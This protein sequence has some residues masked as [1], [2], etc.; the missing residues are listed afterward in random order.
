MT[1]VAVKPL[2]N[3]TPAA[4]PQP[5]VIRVVD[6]PVGSISP[7]TYDSHLDV[8]LRLGQINN[9]AGHLLGRALKMMVRHPAKTALSFL[10]MTFE[11]FTHPMRGILRCV[12]SFTHDGFLD[13]IMT[14]ALYASSAITTASFLA[15]A[16]ALLA[17]PFTGGASLAIIPIASSIMFYTGLSDAAMTAGMLAKDEYDGAHA[18]SEEKVQS[19]EQRLADDY[20]NAF[21][22][23]VTLPLSDAS[24]ALTVAPQGML[25]AA[26]GAV[27]PG[28]RNAGAAGVR[29][30][31]RGVATRA[32]ARAVDVSTRTDSHDTSR[33][34]AVTA[35][36]P[37]S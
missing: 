7:D 35:T 30:V 5:P 9:E 22:A 16:V 11:P 17:A 10:L 19:V 37:R 29:N 3:Q 20:L 21:F 32:A 27:R 25:A 1:Y 34:P 15:M 23:W 28:L 2:A 8:S 12:D 14:S 18:N 6:A 13:G 4:G 36:A 31:S 26:R 24:T 33:V